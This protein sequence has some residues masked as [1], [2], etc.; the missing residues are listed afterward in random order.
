MTCGK[1]SVD[2]GL[3]TFW[4]SSNDGLCDCGLEVLLCLGAGFFAS[5]FKHSGRL[6]LMESVIWVSG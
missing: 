2:D 6:G 5:G 3:W 1:C 4:H